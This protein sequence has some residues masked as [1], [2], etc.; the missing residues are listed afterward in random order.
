[1]CLC[2]LETGTCTASA[3]LHPH[4]H[5]CPWQQP[6]LHLQAQRRQRPLVARHVHARGAGLL[7]LPVL[8]AA[9][10]HCLQEHDDDHQQKQK[11]Q[12]GKR[13]EMTTMKRR[14]RRRRPEVK[15]WPWFVLAAAKLW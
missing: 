15:P 9:G 14:R 5:H 4:P 6:R 3:P 7:L 10:P 2:S 1:M 12:L 11:Q 13:R 8:F